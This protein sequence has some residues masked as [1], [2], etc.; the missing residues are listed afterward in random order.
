MAFIAYNNKRIK[1][2]EN[3]LFV[4]YAER[5]H[6]GI[7]GFYCVIISHAS[8]ESL[9]GTLFDEGHVS[10][11]IFEIDTLDVDT[12][13]SFIIE[14][15][16]ASVTAHDNAASVIQEVV[17]ENGTGLPVILDRIRILDESDLIDCLS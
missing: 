4:T 15:E 2:M 1:K 6:A 8:I 5:A 7:L 10:G 9:V 3:K 14:G 13:N 17:G 12:I 11:A 16:A